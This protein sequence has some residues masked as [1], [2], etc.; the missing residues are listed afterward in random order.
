MLFSVRSVRSDDV[1][2]I[3]NILNEIIIEGGKTLH[4]N[5]MK[6]L[7]FEKY[8][9]KSQFTVCGHVAIQE[10]SIIGFQLLE[11]SDPNWSGVDKLPSNWGLISTY[12]KKNARRLSAGKQLFHATKL[13]VSK[14]KMFSIIATVGLFNK[15]ANEFHESL[16]FYEYGHFE[17]DTTQYCVSR[18]F[19]LP[20]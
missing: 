2:G 14:T 16:G 1:I 12:I 13:Y 11:W 10:K 8:Y 3:S 17:N 6:P 20:I 15:G 5:T 18:R 9:L 19:D 4:N 7:E